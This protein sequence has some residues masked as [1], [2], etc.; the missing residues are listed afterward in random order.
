MVIV[1]RALTY[2]GYDPWP[3][4]LNYVFWENVLIIP[5]AP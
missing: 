1:V 2:N 3:E 4:N 5:W